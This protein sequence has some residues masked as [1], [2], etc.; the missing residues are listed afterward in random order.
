MLQ[1]LGQRA[2][3]FAEA[4]R[5][6]A[7]SLDD[8][9]GGLELIGPGKDGQAFF[10]GL[11]PPQLV[12]MEELVPAPFTRFNQSVRSG[13]L[14]DEIP[15]VLAGPVV[16]GFE[17]RWIIFSQSLLELVDQESTLFD[18]ADFIQAKQAQLL[19]QRVHG[20]KLLPAIAI[21]AQC[22]GQT[23][24]IQMIGLGAA[25]RFAL[26]ITM[27]RDRVD[28]IDGIAVLEELIDGSSLAGFDRDGQGRPGGRLL[29]KARP[30]FQGVLE[31]KV[32]DDLSVAV[33][34]D[35]RMVVASP[36]EAGVV[37]EVF[38]F[39]HVFSFPSVHRSA[40]VRRSDTRS[41]AG[42]CSLRRWNGRRRTGR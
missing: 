41:L 38:P 29:A 42:Y 1:L 16:E 4:Q 8:R 27:G 24:G 6:A 9:L 18:Q 14:G 20:L 22:I 2:Q 12:S 36:V 23:P 3:E 5:Q 10:D 19:G 28:W 21:H 30:A 11:G 17:R 13:E 34:D 25:G 26:A 15:G 35:H 7:F 32:R 40:V 39:L 31:L 33:D 37:G